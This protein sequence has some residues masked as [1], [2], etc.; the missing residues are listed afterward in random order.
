MARG[1]V[2]GIVE[3]PPHIA[4]RGDEWVG[5]LLRPVRGLPLMVFAPRVPLRS[6]LG[7]DP[8][9]LRGSTALGSKL[10]GPK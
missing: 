10:E 5:L 6:T 4:L 2:S 7:Y 1:L 9:P 8:T 3:R